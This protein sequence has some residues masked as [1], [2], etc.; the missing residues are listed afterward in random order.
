VLQVRGNEAE[1]GG[2][3]Q[4]AAEKL[5]HNLR[6][7]EAL[8]Q[9]AERAADQQQDPDL[10]EEDRDRSP[11]SLAL[12]GQCDRCGA[13][14]QDQCEQDRHQRGVCGRPPHPAAPGA[15]SFQV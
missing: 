4:E 7:A 11:G 12:R 8:H 14:E 15:Q 6:L 9:L 13:A 3:E 1:Q 10:D 5:S 2:A